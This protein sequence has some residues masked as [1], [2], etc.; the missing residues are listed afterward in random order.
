MEKK[1]NDPEDPVKPLPK[2]TISTWDKFRMVVLTIATIIVWI[3]GLV[4]VTPVFFL[5]T[6]GRRKINL[7][8]LHLL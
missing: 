6:K 2:K 4:W 3:L 5:E 7:L 1:E 8:C